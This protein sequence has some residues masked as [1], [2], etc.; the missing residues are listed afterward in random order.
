MTARTGRTKQARAEWTV[1]LGRTRTGRAGRTGQD[2]PPS[3]G[4]NASEST[5]QNKVIVEA[6]VV[7]ASATSHSS[8]YFTASVVLELNRL[9]HLLSL[10][11]YVEFGQLQYVYSWFAR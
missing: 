10:L 11:C 9:I 2:G 6:P 1:G 7:Q 8:A 3:Y 4:V 5:L